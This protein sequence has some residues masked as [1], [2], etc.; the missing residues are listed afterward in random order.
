MQTAKVSFYLKFDK[1]KTETGEAPIYCRITVN[2]IRSNISIN[3]WVHPDR[4]VETDMLRK[5]RK[6]EDQ[7][8]HFYM[9]SIRSR[10]K[11]IERELLDNRIPITSENIK[12]A[13]SGKANKSKT[14]I[15]AIEWHNTQFKKTVDAEMATKATLKRYETVK[16]HVISFLQFQFPKSDLPLEELEENFITNFELFLRSE[17]KDARG[18][19]KKCANNSAVKYIRNFRKII[20]MVVKAKW[21]KHDPFTAYDGKVRESS[22]PFLTPDEI[23]L[24]RNKKID[25]PRLEVIRDIFCFSIFTGYA[26]SDVKKLTYNDIHRHIDG[27]LWIFT[28]RQKTKVE[29]NVLLLDPAIQLIE[30]YRSHPVCLKKGVLFPVPSNQRVNTYLKELADICGIQKKL[31]FHT[32]R[33]S[34]ATSIMLANDIPMETLMTAIGHTRIKQ[35]QHYAKMLNSKVSSDMKRLNEKL[36]TPKSDNSDVSETG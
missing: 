31:T 13:Y 35:T 18:S 20:K 8:L 26:Y 2:G 6:K 19:L 27:E 11:G 1:I 15:D 10:I 33:H 25:V 34:F 30:K 3:R 22:R 29:E 24:I 32:A 16:K 28:D 21:L 23:E 5:A 7:E 17:R 36:R 12:K 14:L 9:E 4:W